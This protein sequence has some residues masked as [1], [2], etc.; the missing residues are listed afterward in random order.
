MTF[1]QIE[2]LTGDATVH[3]IYDHKGFWRRLKNRGRGRVVVIHSLGAIAPLNEDTP[4]SSITFYV[5]P[6]RAPMSPVLDVRI[7]FQGKLGNK[8]IFKD[9]D[10]S[11]TDVER[12]FGDISEVAKDPAE[13]VQFR[14]KG[15]P[16]RYQRS[17][18]VEEIWYPEQGISFVLMSNVVT[19]FQILKARGSKP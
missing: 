3:G 16:F 14:V 13:G 11:K 2:E 15:Q 8:L 17:E 18:S 9:S 10:I 7:P 1:S 12:V 6:Y 19:S 5:R 4:I